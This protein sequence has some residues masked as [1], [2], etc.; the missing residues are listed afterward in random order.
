MSISNL[1]NFNDYGL[2]CKS[3][4]NL[5]DLLIGTNTGIVHIG[6]T[7][8]QVFIN[9]E[10]Y[11][12]QTGSTG[13]PGP[14]GASGQTGQ[15]GSTGA[16]G[17]TGLIG[18]TGISGD[19]GA[20]GSTGEKGD[21]G[22]MGPTGA[23][24]GQTGD[25]GPQ[26]ETGQQGLIGDTGSTGQQGPTGLEGPTG[27]NS[28]Q[29]GPTGSNG[30]Q[31]NTGSTGSIGH[32]GPTG[33]QGNTGATGIQG[34][35][36]NT[37]STGPINGFVGYTV[38]LD[39]LAVP[40]NNKG[41]QIT[42]SP[43]WQIQAFGANATNGGMVLNTT[44]SFGGQK[45]FVND[46][47]TDNVLSRTGGLMAIGANS[48]GLNMVSTSGTIAMDQ[49]TTGGAIT[50]GSLKAT[51]VTLGRAGIT[52]TVNGTLGVG[53]GL[54]SLFSEFV[55]TQNV[56]GAFNVA[57]YLRLSFVRINNNITMNYRPLLI[58]QACVANSEIIL[59]ATILAW[60]PPITIRSSAMVVVNGNQLPGRLTFTVG[61]LISFAI[62]PG[63]NLGVANFVPLT[64]IGVEAGSIDYSAV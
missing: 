34:I 11:S 29:T 10:L 16:T 13:I 41:L 4:D 46:L 56:T 61:G 15:T 23:N 49:I 3:L 24:S 47:Q 57:N 40:L 22:V 38:P 35:Q 51:S 9:G 50:V 18:S 6:S 33:V 42:N 14:I 37:G 12:G 30:I 21:T 5:V 43:T 59:G 26:G 8:S 64:T 55:T 52:T 63:I 19:T 53:G 20:T 28:G 62:Q 7:G 25:T 2:Y 45:I 32:T 39:I 54:I 17:A 48:S 1:L 36:G 44:Q 31:G 60:A 58:N 27:P